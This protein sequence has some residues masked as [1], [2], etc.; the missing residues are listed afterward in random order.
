MASHR[1]LI[2]VIAFAFVLASAVRVSAVEMADYTISV[3]TGGS[4][5]FWLPGDVTAQ[6]LLDDSEVTGFTFDP[7]DNVTRG[8]LTLTE[9]EPHS[10]RI[11]F[12]STTLPLGHDPAVSVSSVPEP[13]TLLILGLGLAALAVAARRRAR[14]ATPVTLRR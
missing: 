12:D 7:V 13:A 6:W 2:V 1:L 10:L 4:Y 9:N 3:E 8:T 11:V 5:E 14:A